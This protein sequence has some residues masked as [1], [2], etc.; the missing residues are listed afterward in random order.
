MKIRY[1]N[2]P[3]NIVATLSNL[4]FFKT[5]SISKE[6]TIGLVLLLTLVEIGSL[7]F[8]YQGQSKSHTRDLMFTIQDAGIGIP[9]A[10]QK[11]IF[12]A[13]EQVSSQSHRIYGGTGLGLAICNKL[14]DAMGGKIQL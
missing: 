12:D 7:S 4:P 8:F 13:F 1:F 14:V 2:G 11:R 9:L 3:F 10:D 6:L 5:R